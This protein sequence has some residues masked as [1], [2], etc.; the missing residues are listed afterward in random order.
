ME[1]HLLFMFFLCVGEVEHVR[2]ETIFL[3]FV[4][5]KLGTMDLRG[6]KR[7]DEREAKYGSV[8]SIPLC[9]GVRWNM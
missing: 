6:L 4:K 8:S 3:R 9:V 2:R 1:V 7:P 5:V